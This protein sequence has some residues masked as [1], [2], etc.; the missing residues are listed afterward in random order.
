LRIALEYYIDPSS[1]L[2][3]IELGTKSNPFKAMDDPFR[4]MFDLAMISIEAKP[5]G[6]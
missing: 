2:S 3:N 4:E 6:E 1:Q 5:A